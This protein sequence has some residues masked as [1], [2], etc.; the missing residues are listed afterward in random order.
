MPD[1]V[2]QKLTFGPRK[3]FIQLLATHTIGN[4]SQINATV[5]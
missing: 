5:S 3:G 2:G 1:N 4:Q